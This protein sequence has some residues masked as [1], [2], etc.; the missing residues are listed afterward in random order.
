M[1]TIF[2]ISDKYSAAL[3]AP[4]SG[5]FAEISNFTFDKVLEK[6][7]HKVLDY[8]KIQGK[9]ENELSVYFALFI[10]SRVRHHFGR[11][12]YQQQPSLAP[13][14]DRHHRRKKRLEEELT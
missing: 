12:R 9:R 11:D 4:S 5:Y 8:K 14:G 2:C 10:T 1:E 3:T 6:V 7:L 13:S